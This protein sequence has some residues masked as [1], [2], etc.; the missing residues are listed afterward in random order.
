MLKLY[1][2]FR[3]G[4]S[5]RT[6]IALNLKGLEYEYL[7]IS[8]GKYENKS[9][10]YKAINPQGLVPALVL[11]SGEVLTQSVAI[12]EWLEEVYPQSSLLPKDPIARARV[13]ALAAIIGCDI[14]PINNKRI[15]EYLKSELGQDDDVTAAWIAEWIHA[16]FSALETLLAKDTT[17]HKGFCFGDTP[18]LADAYLIPQVYSARR[19]GVDLSAYPNIVAIDA[20]CN[21]LDAFKKAHPDNQIDTPK[22]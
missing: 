13:R 19:F 20:H 21:S 4:T 18:T 16:G 10:A 22:I 7:P 14:H 11:E 12:I 8:L 6:C 2:F 1:N 9:D 17:R 5:H 3:S 15:L